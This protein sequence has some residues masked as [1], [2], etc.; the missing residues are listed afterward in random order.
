MLLDLFITF[1]QIGLFSFGGGYAVLPLIQNQAVTAK[2]W[3]TIE[4]F[5]DLV[6]ISQMTPGPIAINAST[7]VGQRVA[8]FAGA[9]VATAGCIAPSCIIALILAYFYYK[10]KSLKLV[11]GGLTGLRPAVVALIAGA[12]VSIAKMAIFYDS[13]DVKLWAL[14]LFAAC[15]F[16][17]R[18]WKVDPIKVIA[19]TGA[20]GAVSYYLK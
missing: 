8:G 7:F 19:V 5:A 20:I 12:G 10:Y 14:P 6:T 2:G 1:F 17:L 15:L 11:Q 9:V 16:A 3:L 13:G 4:E 18:K